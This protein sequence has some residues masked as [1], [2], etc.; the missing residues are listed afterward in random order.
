MTLRI[1]LG[2]GDLTWDGVLNTGYAYFEQ[3]TA[4]ATDTLKTI[5]VNNTSGTRCYVAIY[6][7]NANVPGSYLG[8]TGMVSIVAGWNTIS[9]SDI[10]IVQGT[11]YWLAAL[12]AIN[13]VANGGT[14][15]TLPIADFDTF[16]WPDPPTGL[17]STSRNLGIAG[18]G[19]AT[20]SW[21]G[22]LGG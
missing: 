12:G 18:W 19:D 4:I 11:K 7:D 2:N 10:S 15:K 14:T 21:F 1:L 3:F 16:T 17:S 13:R 8:G 20:A 9:I 22:M 5:R 6:A